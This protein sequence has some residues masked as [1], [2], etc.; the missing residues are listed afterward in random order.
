[1]STTR[2][3]VLRWLRSC[4]LAAAVAG[5]TPVAFAAD[6]ASPG[7]AVAAVRSWSVTDFGGVGDGKAMN[8]D[9]FRKTIEACANAGGGRVLVP[10]GTYL[11]GPIELKSGVDLHVAAGATIQFSHNLDDFPLV[12]SEYE[13]RGTVQARSPIWGEKLRDVSITGAGTIDGAGEA[14]RPLK[15]SKVTPEHWERVTKGGGVVE[16]DGK[17]WWPSR[18]AMEGQRELQRLREGDSRPGAAAPRVEEYAKFKEL[19]RPQMVLL[20]ECRNVVLDGPTFR[21]SPNWNINLNLCENV[22]LRNLSIYNPAYAQNGDGMDLGSCRNV[23]VEDCTVDVGDDAICL[24]SGRDEEGRRRGKPTENVTVRNCTVLHG[25]GG[26]V[27]GSEMSGGV[28]NVSVIN[29][30]FKGTDTGLRFKTTRGRGGV[31]ENVEVSNVAMSD[32]AGEAI[33]FDMFY[34]VKD[35][36]PEPVSERTPVFRQFYIRNVTCDGAKQA[37]AVRG[38]PELPIEGLTFERVRITADEGAMFVDARDVVLRDVQIRSRQSPPLQ[39]QNV[40]NLTTE[41]VD[42]VVTGAVTGAAAA[43][44][45]EKRNAAKESKPE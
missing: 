8:T 26:V 44:K 31:V 2:S 21:N 5:V 30:V 16:P 1:M 41:R 43:Q 27:I 9:A 20:T 17:T 10:A 37:M 34:A 19:L 13:G 38:L 42:G 35:P 3:S 36:R 45:P 25:H 39:F 11:T 14:W 18:A 7:A 23:L 15:K 24:K 4:V 29:C 22:R 40:R 12:A 32:I 33:T 6:A 28:R